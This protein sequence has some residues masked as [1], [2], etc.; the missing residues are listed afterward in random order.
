M[1]TVKLDE[2]DLLMFELPANLLPDSNQCVS[3]DGIGRIDH[4]EIITMDAS[5]ESNGENLAHRFENTKKI[6]AMTTASP[7][8]ELPLYL[9][10]KFD[11]A[12]NLATC[13]AQRVNYKNAMKVT[14]DKCVDTSNR[15]DQGISFK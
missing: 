5:S 11:T 10:A 14:T 2:D 12:H 9:A 8:C 4:R 6:L 7:K 3:Q 1:S 15:L 13:S